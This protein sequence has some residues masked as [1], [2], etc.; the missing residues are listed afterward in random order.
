MC[1]CKEEEE[2]VE[3][4]NYRCPNHA[5]LRKKPIKMYEQ[6]NIDFHPPTNIFA[7][8]NSPVRIAFLPKTNWS[9]YFFSLAVLI[10]TLIMFSQNPSAKF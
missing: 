9:V 5:L 6:M 2:T 1:N 8:N 4:F 7:S 3:Y 10:S